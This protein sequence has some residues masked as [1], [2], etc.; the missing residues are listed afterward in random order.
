MA[1]PHILFPPFSLIFFEGVVM[2]GMK[3]IRPDLFVEESV[4]SHI[5]S[6]F[7]PPLPNSSPSNLRIKSSQ[8]STDRK[9]KHVDALWP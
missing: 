4:K 9:K 5:L 3:N 2:K 6:S 8:E 1:H 7:W